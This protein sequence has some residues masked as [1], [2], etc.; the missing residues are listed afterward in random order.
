MDSYFWHLRILLSVSNWKEL[1]F[2]QLLFWSLLSIYICPFTF[3]PHPPHCDTF[4]HVEFYVFSFYEF[5][6]PFT[7]KY[8]VFSGHGGLVIYTVQFYV[9]VSDWKHNQI[10]QQD[11]MCHFIRLA[12][13]RLLAAL[14][15]QKMVTNWVVI[16]Q[17]R[18]HPKINMSLMYKL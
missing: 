10:L 5:V 18:S 13:K 3:F 8:S 16:F 9:K 14:I 6:Y 12:W 2:F 7:L 17:L 11:I 1:H 4:I 15:L